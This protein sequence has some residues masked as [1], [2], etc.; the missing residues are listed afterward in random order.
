MLTGSKADIVLEL[1][2][3]KPL[4]T[5]WQRRCVEILTMVSLQFGNKSDSFD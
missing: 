1:E 3:G 2:L 5:S 4:W